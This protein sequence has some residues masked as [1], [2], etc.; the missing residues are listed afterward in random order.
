VKILNKKRHKMSSESLSSAIADM[1]AELDEITDDYAEQYRKRIDELLNNPESRD[2]NSWKAWK[3]DERLFEMTTT[4]IEKA[5]NGVRDD[6]WLFAMGGLRAACVKQAFTEIIAP[7]I[8]SAVSSGRK[9]I[10]KQAAKMD[11]AELR[12]HAKIGTPK[13]EFNAAKDRRKNAKAAKGE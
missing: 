10:A 11:R 8:L 4:A 2:L 5:T 6:I 7:R 13:S 9:S 3:V 1:H 12:Q